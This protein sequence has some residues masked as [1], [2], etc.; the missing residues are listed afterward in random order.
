MSRRAEGKL[1]NLSDKL[2]K[3]PVG[4]V[5]I[6]A[7]AR[8]TNEELW[9]LSKLK[10]KLGALSDSIPRTGP[11]DKLLVSDDKNPNTNGAFGP[12]FGSHQYSGFNAAPNA[13]GAAAQHKH[14]LNFVL[15]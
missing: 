9:L 1:I 12:A 2:K 15:Q 8:Q 6:V 14:G 13:L 4:S 5:A 10:A 7:S 11:A 3:A